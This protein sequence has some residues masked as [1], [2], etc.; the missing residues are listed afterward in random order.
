MEMNPSSVRV[1]RGRRHPCSKKFWSSLRP[2]RF[3]QGKHIY[4]SAPLEGEWQRARDIIDGRE[5]LA[6]GAMDDISGGVD[7]GRQPRAF[8]SKRDARVWTVGTG[9]NYGASGSTGGNL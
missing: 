3:E 5:P 6:T 1:H 7:F 9:C 2:Q 4:A 8:I